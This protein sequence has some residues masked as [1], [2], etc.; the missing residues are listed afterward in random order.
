MT[1]EST[2]ENRRDGGESTKEVD[3]IIK[4]EGKALLL[5]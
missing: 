3:S 1:G 2:C 4:E 5:K